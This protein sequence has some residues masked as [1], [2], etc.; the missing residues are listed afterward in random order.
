MLDSQASIEPLTLERTIE[1]MH[2]FIPFCTEEVKELK[3][4][5]DLCKA[6]FNLCESY[7]EENKWVLEHTYEAFKH[8]LNNSVEIQERKKQLA[9]ENEIKEKE[10]KFKKLYEKHLMEINH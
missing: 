8:Y 5:L 4:Y 2:F 9:Y 6:F 7:T 10:N 1:N 3:I